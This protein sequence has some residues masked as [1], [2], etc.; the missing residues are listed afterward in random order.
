MGRGVSPAGF[1]W[2][3]RKLG[4]FAL[5]PLPGFGRE[6]SGLSVLVKFSVLNKLEGGHLGTPIGREARVYIPVD[7]ELTATTKEGGAF[8]STI[9]VIPSI[10]SEF[11][12]RAR[13]DVANRGMVC[14]FGDPDRVHGFQSLTTAERADPRLIERSHERANSRAQP[15]DLPFGLTTPCELVAQRNGVEISFNASPM[16]WF[17]LKRLAEMH[18]DRYESRDLARDCWKEAG[19]PPPSDAKAS[20][21]TEI[22]KLR[23][24]IKPLGLAIPTARG[25][26]GYLLAIQPD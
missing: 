20:L 22:T 11:E 3:C 18:P 14:V 25:K 17:L 6:T 15:G 12:K 9:G 8:L 13:L 7:K 19:R 21:H 2:K 10:C 23:I 4:A 26:S 24:L 16:G 1:V 5:Y